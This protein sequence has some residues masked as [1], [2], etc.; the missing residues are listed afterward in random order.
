MIPNGGN[1]G[2][3]VVN[4]FSSFSSSEPAPKALLQHQYS[5]PDVVIGL[6]AGV[7]TLNV[8]VVAFCGRLARNLRRLKNRMALPLFPP[9]SVL[10]YG[11]RFQSLRNFSRSCVIGLPGLG[12]PAPSLLTITLS[13]RS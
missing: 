2:S 7:A 6:L 1:L 8:N 3:P 12:L 9:S 13:N 11:G 4:G 10:K 5:T